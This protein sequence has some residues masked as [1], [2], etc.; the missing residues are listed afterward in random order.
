ML[1]NLFL[2]HFFFIPYGAALGDRIYNKLHFL[3]LI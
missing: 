1:L 3:D 2:F